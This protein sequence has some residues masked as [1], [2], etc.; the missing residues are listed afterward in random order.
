MRAYITFTRFLTERQVTSGLQTADSDGTTTALYDLYY[1][2]GVSLK[3]QRVAN[4]FI[5][6]A[7]ESLSL[8]KVIAPDMW[9]RM[10]GRGNGVNFSGMTARHG[11]PVIRTAPYFIILLF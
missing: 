4:P 10:I 1:Q 6:E 3:R 5:S 7:I 11:N 9:E 2:T 8:Y